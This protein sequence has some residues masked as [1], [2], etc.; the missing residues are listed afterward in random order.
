MPPE[1]F[2]ILGSVITLVILSLLLS[3]LHARLTKPIKDLCNQCKLGLVTETFASKQFS[4]VKTIREYIR[5]TQDRAET[6]A[7]Q[8]EK[9]ETELFSTRKERDRSF[10]K[11]EE[12]EDL[13][14]S[15]VRIRAE[16]NID[17]SSLRREN[18]R[19]N[20]QIDALRRK[21]FGTSS[22]K[23]LHSLD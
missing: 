3:A 10:R 23:R 1:Y 7:G 6:R 21:E 5:L 20:E 4:E 15:Y 12:F 18:Q 2:W 16:L 8:I 14:A 19:L 22:A 13:V 17:N 9:M 11:V